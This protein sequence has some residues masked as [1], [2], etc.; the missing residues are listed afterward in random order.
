MLL[1]RVVG[2]V[3]PCVVYQGL[4]GTPMLMIQPLDKAGQP[5]GRALVAADATR[6]AG[7]GELVH[8]EG[9]REAALALDPWFVP[10]DHTIIGIVDAVHLPGQEEPS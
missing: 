9:G 10:V 7:P 2:V 6:M 8:Y 1:A 5:K 3:V 4:E